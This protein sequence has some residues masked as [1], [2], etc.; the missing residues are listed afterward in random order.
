MHR[1]RRR[2]GAGAGAAERRA[3][4]AH[5]RR[6]DRD[7]GGDPRIHLKR[8]LILAA[9]LAVAVVRRA[10]ALRGLRL[11]RR[12]AAQLSLGAV[13]AR[14]GADGAELPAPLLP[15]AALPGAAGDR[16]SARPQLRDLRRRADDDDHAREARR[17]AQVRPLEALTF[18]VPVRRSAPVVLRR[19]R[20]RRDRGGRA[21]GRR[22]ARAPELAAAARRRGRRRRRAVLVVRSPLL[23]RWSRL[24]EAPGAAR[25]LL[26]T[27]LLVEMTAALRGVVALR[28]P[29]GLRVRQ[30]AAPRPLARR[31]DRRLH[32]RQPGR[33]ALVPAGRPRRRR[34]EHGR[35]DQGPRRH[36]EGRRRRPP[37]S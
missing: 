22:R 36:D 26:G 31:H 19:A 24:G 6:L 12:R 28:V 7:R 18:D 3:D 2:R 30:G 1:R 5:G 16:D 29:R 37:R 11:A 27:R 8:G 9:A 21:G 4:H 33:R 34:D 25:A 14:A 23:D 35:A 32:A 20:D 15:L 17:A 10:R 13:P